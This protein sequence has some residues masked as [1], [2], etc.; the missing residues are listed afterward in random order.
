M[1]EKIL[2]V[3]CPVNDE[4]VP[5][6]SPKCP[7]P[8]PIT[9]MERDPTIEEVRRKELIRLAAYYRVEPERLLKQRAAELYIQTGDEKALDELKA[10]IA[11]LRVKR[12][13]TTLMIGVL[14]AGLIYL[15]TRDGYTLI[16]AGAIAW[17]ICFYLDGRPSHTNRTRGRSRDNLDRSDRDS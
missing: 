7:V 6:K 5:V 8:R 4:G 13:A 10:W 15:A 3:F 17:V 11:V 12:A 16:S 2:A 1:Q 14:A 9:I